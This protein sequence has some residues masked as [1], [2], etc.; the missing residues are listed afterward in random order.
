MKRL[1]SIL[2]GVVL[3]VSSLFALQDGTYRCVNYSVE[4]LKTGITIKIPENEMK[5]VEFK[6]NDLTLN[7]GKDKWKY[8]FTKDNFDV[9]KIVTKNSDILTLLPSNSVKNDEFFKGGI[10]MPSDNLEIILVCKR[11]GD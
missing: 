7:D 11:V 2:A 1:V 4:N 6:V 5:V 3:S 10:L 8:V 9:F